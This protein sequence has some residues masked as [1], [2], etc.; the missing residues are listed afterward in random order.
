MLYC[1]VNMSKYFVR[2]C[3]RKHI[4]VFCEMVFTLWNV[5][6]CS[7]FTFRTS[8]HYNNLP[9]NNNNNNKN[10]E[11]HTAHMWNTCSHL[12]TT[13]IAVSTAHLRKEWT[14]QVMPWWKWILPR[15]WRYMT[16][17]VLWRALCL[18]LQ[19][20]KTTTTTFLEMCKRKRNIWHYHFNIV[21]LMWY[22]C[23][24]LPTLDPGSL[25]LSLQSQSVVSHLM[26]WQLFRS[27]KSGQWENHY[28]HVHRLINFL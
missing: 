13:C 21:Y 17:Q 22:Y 11:V 5:V 1:F 24:S 3:V 23:Y 9:K 10:P 19:H 6:F 28:W 18:Q 26:S 20:P 2:C 8:G 25:T 7:F 16:F 27:W 12:D 4:A 15:R 14:L